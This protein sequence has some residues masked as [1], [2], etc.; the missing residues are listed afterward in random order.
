MFI[1]YLTQ[2]I[3][4]YLEYLEIQSHFAK[5]HI[6]KKCVRK[7]YLETHSVVSLCIE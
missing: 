5:R 3:C 7:N 6:S 4:K 2:K 1:V